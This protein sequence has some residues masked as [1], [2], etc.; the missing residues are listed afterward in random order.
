VIDGRLY[1]GTS[2]APRD[3]HDGISV[4]SILESWGPLTRVT[5]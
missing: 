5:T 4:E 1:G 2:W 3:R